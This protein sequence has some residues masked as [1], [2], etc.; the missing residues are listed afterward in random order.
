[1]NEMK[2]FKCPECKGEFKKPTKYYTWDD[3]VVYCCPWCKKELFM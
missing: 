2:H 3:S 1:M